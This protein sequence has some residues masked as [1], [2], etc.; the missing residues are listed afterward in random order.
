MSSL[1]WI[2][3]LKPCP[4]ARTGFDS[5]RMQISISAKVHDRKPQGLQFDSHRFHAPGFQHSSVLSTLEQ[6]LPGRKRKLSRGECNVPSRPWM[7]TYREPWGF[8]YPARAL[9]L[10]VLHGLVANMAHY[11]GCQR[12]EPCPRARPGFDSHRTQISVSAKVID[13]KPQGSQFNSHR[14]QFQISTPFRA[15]HVRTA[16]SGA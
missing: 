4:R 13:P 10:K 3:L 15:Q 12:L 7:A 9:C 11:I 14:V 5:Y 6:P 1:H 8:P 2:Q 16:A